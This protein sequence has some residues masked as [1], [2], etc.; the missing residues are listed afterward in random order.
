MFTR[1]QYYEMADA[2]LERFDN[3]LEPALDWLNKVIQ[4]KVKGKEIMKEMTLR[5]VKRVLLGLDPFIRTD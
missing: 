5:T 3:D 4:T 2:L 1:K